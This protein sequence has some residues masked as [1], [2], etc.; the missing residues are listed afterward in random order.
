M[1]NLLEREGSVSS[2]NPV[3]ERRVLL[4]S[5]RLQVKERIK[6][7]RLPLFIIRKSERNDRIAR[8]WQIPGTS[9][10][11]SPEG[12]IYYP[13][14][15]ERSHVNDSSLY[16]SLSRPPRGWTLERL[17]KSERRP[18]SEVVFNQVKKDKGAVETAI[19]AMDHVLEKFQERGKEL[20]QVELLESQIARAIEVLQ[21][22]EGVSREEFDQHFEELYRQ[23]ADLLAKSGMQRAQLALKRDVERLME[24]A[25]AGRDKL[26]RKN[27]LIMVGKLQ[28]ATRRISYRRNEAGFVVSKF[29]A[30]KAG[31]LAQRRKDREILGR[32]QHDLTA[33]F[34]RHEVFKFPG[35][36]VS[37]M[38]RGILLGLMRTLIYQLDQTRVKP[39]KS[40]AEEATAR[41]RKARLLTEQENYQEATEVFREISREVDQ[42][43]E[44]PEK[45]TS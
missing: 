4:A 44:A 24:E 8:M 45:T 20:Q 31:L 38:Q 1:P 17:L 10:R 5:E 21:S 32:C 35:R 19:R 12:D 39:Y 40:V 30:M 22:T 2:P 26:G 27:P 25:S 14:W 34:A 3:L 23:T 6:G 42:V 16:T 13:V 15:R 29:E 11:V 18:I 43:L 28:A 33:G 36:K 37:K 41:L 9:V 7:E